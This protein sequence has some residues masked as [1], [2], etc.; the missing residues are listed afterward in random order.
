LIF[1]FRLAQ[2]ATEKSA[3]SEIFEGETKKR[4][5][6]GRLKSQARHRDLPLTVWLTACTATVYNY[7][8]I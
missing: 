7:L 8:F 3:F 5:R 2:T 4:K 1:F 6:I